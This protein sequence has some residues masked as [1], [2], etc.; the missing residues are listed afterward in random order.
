MTDD[1]RDRLW[2]M[3]D[4]FEIQSVNFSKFYIPSKHLAVD[5]G[6]VTWNGRVIFKLFILQKCNVLASECRNYVTPLVTHMTFMC[7]WVRTDSG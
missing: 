5:E 4:L 2:K 1:S 7:T 6:I 3:Q